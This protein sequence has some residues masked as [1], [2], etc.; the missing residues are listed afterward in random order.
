MDRSILNHFFP[1]DQF[2]I[3][4][5]D[6]SDIQE[7]KDQERKDKERKD[8]KDTTARHETCLWISHR[9]RLILRFP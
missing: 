3:E 6:T 8:H 2:V 1:E 7:R 4:Y 5:R 9:L